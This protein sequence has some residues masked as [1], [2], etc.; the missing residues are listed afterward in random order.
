MVKAV[1]GH[2]SLSLIRENLLKHAGCDSVFDGH[3]GPDTLEIN[4]PGRIETQE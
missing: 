3:H 1:M 2:L 4:I